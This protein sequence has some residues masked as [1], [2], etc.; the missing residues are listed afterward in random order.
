MLRTACEM[1]CKPCGRGRK[2]TGLCLGLVGVSV[3]VWVGVGTGGPEAAL[4]AAL[5]ACESGEGGG[6]S[7]EELPGK[8]GPRYILF[9]RRGRRCRP[10]VPRAPWLGDSVRT[11]S[12]DGGEI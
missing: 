11:D 1:M 4:E 7:G 3:G 12:D 2:H 5:G 10:C 6:G 9:C 8:E